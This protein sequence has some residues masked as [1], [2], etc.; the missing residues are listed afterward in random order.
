MDNLDTL[1]LM[2]FHGVYLLDYLVSYQWA[3]S[4]LGVNKSFG[5]HSPFMNV[6][7]L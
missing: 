4:K 5:C 3:V 6:H 2:P 7:E 1:F